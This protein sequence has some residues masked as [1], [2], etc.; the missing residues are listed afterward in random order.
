MR[1]KSQGIAVLRARIRD[2]TADVVG[3]FVSNAQALGTSAS[4]RAR[5]R[6]RHS[7][8]PPI[9]PVVDRFVPKPR[10]LRLKYPMTFVGEIQE[11]RR[12]LQSLQRR[13]ELKSF[14]H[15]E[16]IIILA[17]NHQRRRFEFVGEQVR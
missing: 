15:V 9:H 3:A 1:A 17:M 14:T 6:A 13:E 10:I 8:A 12:N 7:L 11:L 5:F 4:T 16:P 2:N